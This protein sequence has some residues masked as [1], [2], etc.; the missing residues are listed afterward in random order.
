MNFKSIFLLV[1]IFS[2]GTGTLFA[3][4]KSE[5]EHRIRKSQFPEKALMGIEEK[6]ENARQ[7]RFYKEIDSNEVSY[8]VKF[9]KDRLRYGIK[10]NND[11]NI[12]DIEFEIKPV[13]I[14]NDSY[15]QIIAYLE[16]N[17]EK[18]RVQKIQ[19][20]YLTEGND[21]DQ[22]LK[23]AFQNLML[24]SITY[25]FSVK[26]RKN[27]KDVEKFEIIFNAE[28]KLELI[29]KALPPNYDHILY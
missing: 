14:P 23:D 26:G 1:F 20:Q 4:V 29:K 24:P 15:S 28:G 9:K 13:D 21:I 2:F 25:K 10:F 22:S 7:I 17:F 3:Q 16:N 27:G 19:Q 6:L 11:S 18:Y 8:K 12:E 5:R